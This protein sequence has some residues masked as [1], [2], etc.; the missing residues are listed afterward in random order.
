MVLSDT[1]PKEENSS[2]KSALCTLLIIASQVAMSFYTIVT[3]S[4]D[5]LNLRS[6]HIVPP[7]LFPLNPILS[8]TYFIL[9]LIICIVFS[10]ISK[11]KYLLPPFFASI[12]TMSIITILIW[13]R[14]TII[15]TASQLQSFPS[16]LLVVIIVVSAFFQVIAGVVETLVLRWL[17]SL[18]LNKISR[19]SYQIDSPFETVAKTVAES[20][21]ELFG[22]RRIQQKDK[23][24]LYVYKPTLFGSAIVLALGSDPIQTSKTILAT[25]AYQEKIDSIDKSVPAEQGL[26]TIIAGLRTKLPVTFTEL[27]VAQLKKDPSSQKA[28]EYAIAPTR[29]KIERI[30]KLKIPAIYLWSMVATIILL[31]IINALFLS[32]MFPSFDFNTDIS[33]TV[34]LILAIFVELGIPLYE[35]AKSSKKEESGD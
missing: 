8:I 28:Y 17:M 21:L 32:N 26:T 5:L 10:W 23:A 33:L 4:D 30:Q 31:V 35:I 12:G 3:I 19:F 18:N 24:V 2:I 7:F 9:P 6:L 20:S 22:F 25:V 1:R 29:S 11:S 27:K 13:S 15:G 34:T 14:I 16:Y